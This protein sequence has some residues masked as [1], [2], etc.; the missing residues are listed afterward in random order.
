MS[1][2]RVFLGLLILLLLPVT[3]GAQ[4]SRLAEVA[5]AVGQYFL[6]PYDAGKASRAASSAAGAAS[7]AD[8]EKRA[9]QAFV[10]SLGDPYTTW[11]SREDRAMLEAQLSGRSFTG[12]GVEVAPDPA[13][14][15]VVAALDG[16]PAKAAGLKPGDVIEGV[17]GKVLRGMSYYAAADTLLG[18]VGSTVKLALSNR[19]A[20]LQRAVL[21]L[22]PLVV[23]M[24][25]GQVAYVKIPIFGPQT[26]QEVWP[27]MVTLA[28]SG[29][30]AFIIDLRD[31]PGGDLKAALTLLTGL[32]PGRVLVR[33]RKRSGPEDA[34]T[35]PGT[36][37][38]RTLPMIVLVNRG[39][40]SSAEVFSAAL[41]DNGLAKL[42]GE[43]T[44]GKGLIQT[45]IPLRDGSE[46]KVT[47]ARYL[48]PNGTDIHGRGI[49][50]S[51]PASGNDIE[52]KAAAMLR[53]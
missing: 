4:Q 53:K 13:G 11:L 8:K 28:R 15:V 38:E 33:V 19:T 46:L 36:P 5:A 25:D 3:A 18:P 12:I 9:T 43:R 34:R 27:S 29:A 44:F 20:T 30:R 40:A 50:P 22:P 21:R 45:V 23:R 51:I 14:L 10:E 42:M 35:A 16:T 1:A 26:A 48:T 6:F 32:A 39:T 24:L 2:R 37:R 31:N 41:A 7:P 47:S 17:D 49:E 52:N